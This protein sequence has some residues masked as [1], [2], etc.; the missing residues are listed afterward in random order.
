MNLSD[1]RAAFN[2]TRLFPMARSNTK[3][4]AG[5]ICIFLGS[6]EFYG[7]CF[8]GSVYRSCTTHRAI[9]YVYTRIYSNAFSISRIA[10][11]DREASLNT[12]II[13]P[14]LSPSLLSPSPR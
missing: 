1:D 3:R 9:R 4:L 12:A 2:Q 10:L 8:A 5:S 11:T 13:S 7:L 14:P 6:V